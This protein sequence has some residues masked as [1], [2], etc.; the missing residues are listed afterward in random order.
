MMRRRLGNPAIA[1]HDTRVPPRRLHWTSDSRLVLGGGDQDETPERAKDDVLVQRTGDL[2]YGLL[3]MYYAISGL[4]P[5]YGWEAAYGETA[6]RLMYIG[7]HRNYPRHLFA[8][9][10]GAD[11]VTGSFV[12]ARILVRAL[13]GAPDKSDAVFAWTR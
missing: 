2:M 1:L 10:G 5:E 9:G 4:K 3:T 8:L 6:D 12:A 13:Q 7:P 11:S